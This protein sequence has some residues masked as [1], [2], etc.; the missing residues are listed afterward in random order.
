[1]PKKNAPSNEGLLGAW[2]DMHGPCGQGLGE[3]LVRVNALSRFAA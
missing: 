3:G 2:A 1:M